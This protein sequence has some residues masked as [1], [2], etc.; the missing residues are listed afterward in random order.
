MN[1]TG[2][3]DVNRPMSYYVAGSGEGLVGGG[4]GFTEILPNEYRTSLTHDEI[5]FQEWND[6]LGWQAIAEPVAVRS[7]EDTL[8]WEQNVLFGDGAIVT[9]EPP[10][11]DQYARMVFLQWNTVLP[12]WSEGATLASEGS[13]RQDFSRF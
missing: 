11:V 9:P 7:Y 5:M 4:I 3:L 1:T 6:P 2:G 8:F 13:D 10:V 12:G